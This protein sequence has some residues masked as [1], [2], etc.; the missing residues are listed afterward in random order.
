MNVWKE[1]KSVAFLA[2]SGGEFQSFAAWNLKL[3]FSNIAV[4]G[5]GRS[6]KFVF[7]TSFIWCFQMS[8]LN[9]LWWGR[10]DYSHWQNNYEHLVFRLFTDSSP[11]Q[12]NSNSICGL[13]VGFSR[14]FSI[15]HF[16]PYKVICFEINLESRDA[17]FSF[18]ILHLSNILHRMRFGRACVHI[19][20]KGLF[21]VFVLCEH[22]SGT[23]VYILYMCV[24]IGTI[25]V[26]K[27]RYHQNSE[28]FVGSSKSSSDI[29]VLLLA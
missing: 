19:H 20:V 29:L 4:L 2:S 21:S 16:F 6:S 11:T 17:N 14:R 22:P 18:K 24:K 12:T 8:V 1:F 15:F 9:L 3:L 5:L 7:L 10:C 13:I 28:Y 25:R 27:L 26:Q 23:L